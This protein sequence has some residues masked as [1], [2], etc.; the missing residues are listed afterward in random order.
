MPSFLPDTEPILDPA[1]YRELFE[2]GDPE[3]A[4]WMESYLATAARGLEDMRRALAVGD[5]KELAAS[6]HRIGGSSLIV[7]ARRLGLLC[8]RIEIEASQKP[9]PE[10]AAMVD[11]AAL[12]F[13]AARGEIARF[14]ARR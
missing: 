1:P 13:D 7:G 14:I 3:G 10:L 11:E 4:A 12:E 2:N 5:R 9:V 6:A 8:Q